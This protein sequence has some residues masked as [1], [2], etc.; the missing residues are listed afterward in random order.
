[1]ER[2]QGP[3]IRQE[4]FHML[5]LYPTPTLCLHTIDVKLAGNVVL[6]CLSYLTYFFLAF[7]SPF[8]LCVLK[9]TDEPAGS[10][11]LKPPDTGQVCIT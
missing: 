9:T 1:M 2:V 10:L 4:S 8:P 6:L 3:A 11:W 5:Y 7:S